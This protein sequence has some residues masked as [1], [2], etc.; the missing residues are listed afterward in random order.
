MGMINGQLQKHIEVEIE[1]TEL[2]DMPME[3][4]ECEI[5]FA[6]FKDKGEEE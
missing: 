6:K 5:E 2:R 1:L 4:L 3:L